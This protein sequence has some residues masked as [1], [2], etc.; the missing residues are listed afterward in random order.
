MTGLS[1][2]NRDEERADREQQER[3]LAA[4]DASP[5]QLR[6]DECGSWTISGRR[7]TI[8]TWG[9]GESWLA[10]VRCRSRQHWT[11]T[12]RRLTF[13]TV[14]QDGDEE[15]CLR[16]LRLP[17]SEEAAAIRDVMGLRKRVDYA[18]AAL[19]RKRASMAK[20]GLARGAASATVPEVGM[21]DA[22]DGLF[23]PEGGPVVER[24]GVVEM[25]EVLHDRCS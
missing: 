5:S 2:R 18:P 11:F 1:Y 20:A 19:E 6:R 3:L 14:T 25:E 12:K 17:I 13:M 9:D 23:A 24:A 10:Y 15:G 7:G 4:L 22:A 8:H 21:P 16:L